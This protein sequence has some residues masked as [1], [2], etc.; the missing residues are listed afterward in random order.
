ML[1]AGTYGAYCAAKL[2]GRG[3]RVLLLDAGT[4]VIPEHV[5]NLGNIELRVPR[6]KPDPNGV[7][8][9][10]WRSNVYFPGLAFCAGGRSMFSGGWLARLSADD[11]S[12]WPQRAAADLEAGYARLEE[13][14]GVVPA[15][16]F[17]DGALHT[18]L[19]PMVREAAREVP[20]LRADEVGTAPLAVQ[21]A[22]PEFGLFPFRKF[23]SLPV[24][25]N[26][27]RD[28][29]LRERRRLHFVPRATALRLWHGNGVV[30]ALDVGLPGR[31]E[32]L[33]ILPG[34]TVVL[35]L[36]TVESTRLA[37]NSFPTPAMGRGLMIHTRSDFVARIHRSA[38]PARDGDRL[39]VAT[40]L[41]RGAT[42]TGRFH[43]QITATTGTGGADDPL[44][45]TI[46]DLDH[47]DR[48]R[49]TGVDPEWV[50]VVIRAVGE[51]HG[52]PH[53]PAGAADGNWITVDSNHPDG[54]QVPTAYVNVHLSR[55]DLDTWQAMDAAAVALLGALAPDPE[56]IRYWYGTSWHRTPFPLGA[57]GFPSWHWPLGD[58]HHEVGGLRMGDDPATS[59]TDPDGRFHHLRNAYA[60]DGSVFPS[61]GSAGPMLTGL[62]LARRL[63]DHL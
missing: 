44:F 34:C 52:D 21:A 23:S 48:L 31:R 58:S 17:V 3:K 60:C 38:L 42:G 16:D 8:W 7:W 43:F 36:G 13:E 1:G 45:R 22:S 10:P 39:G 40:I 53:T 61:C 15:W 27:V 63:A 41:A 59:V 49:T 32:R 30:R 9:S 12:G 5:Q 20:G 50:T 2:A 35:A 24:L 56:K 33:P 46:P 55:A 57:D 19:L 11:L 14:T 37:L 6:G 26:A 54:F 25:L 51:T 28:D 62:T 18:T 29:R 47:L 4:V